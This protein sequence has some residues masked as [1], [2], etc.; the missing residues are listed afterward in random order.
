MINKSQNL[1]LVLANYI[2][3]DHMKTEGI[4]RKS[5]KNSFNSTLQINTYGLGGLH[6]C[7]SLFLERA[8]A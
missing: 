4:D 7:G 8:V 3:N 1:R 2:Q 6:I 5:L